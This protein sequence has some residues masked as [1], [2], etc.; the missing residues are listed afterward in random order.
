MNEP[1]THAATAC[2]LARL[3]RTQLTDIRGTVLK[4][5]SEYHWDEDMT[6]KIEHIEV[7]LAKVFRGI[8]A[9]LKCAQE[10]PCSAS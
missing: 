3:T 5:A 7:A 2:D 6:P 8:N 10:K 1:N 4:I 9:L